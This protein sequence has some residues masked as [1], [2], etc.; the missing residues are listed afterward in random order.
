MVIA[1]AFGEFIGSTTIVFAGTFVR[2]TNNG[3]MTI[4]GLCYFFLYMALISAFT[5]SSAGLFNPVLTAGLFLFKQIP[6]AKGIAYLV[7]QL[8][9]SFVGAMMA[10]FVFYSDTE[11]KNSR[12]VQP[13]IERNYLYLSAVLEG[14]VLCLLSIVFGSIHINKRAPKF[15]LG[16]AIASVYLFGKL[17]FGRVSGGAFNF[18]EIFGPSVYNQ[19]FENWVFFLFGHVIGVV[20]GLAIYVLILK[21]HG[22]TGFE[23]D[24]DD[25]NQLLEGVDKQ[26]QPEKL[27]GE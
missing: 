18:V 9:G 15:I 10:A 4:I 2:I 3:N 21:D 6:T 7:S 14:I 16:T 20:I 25:N 8:A 23:E 11:N 19:R 1:S 26:L 17:A 27:V 24:L 22:T 12:L 5:P 13:M